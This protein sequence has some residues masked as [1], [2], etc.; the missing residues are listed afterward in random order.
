MTNTLADAAIR[1]GAGIDIA[2]LRARML[3][4][5]NRGDDGAALLDSIATAELPDPLRATVLLL[6]AANLLWIQA[7]P[8]ASWALIDDALAGETPTVTPDL[9]VFRANQLATAGNPAEAIALLDRIDRT[10]LPPLAAMLAIWG[11]TIAAGD[12]GQVQRAR[13][14]PRRASR[15]LPPHPR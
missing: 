1:A 9:L 10:Q 6:R 15:S 2:L 11:L 14:T 5:L 4:L 12:L 3:V 8:E 7:Q 13:P